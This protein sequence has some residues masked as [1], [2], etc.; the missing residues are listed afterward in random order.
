MCVTKI[1]ARFPCFIAFIESTQVSTIVIIFRCV[2][3]SFG[4][5]ETGMFTLG[6]YTTFN[7]LEVSIRDFTSF[8]KGEGCLE[9]FS[10]LQ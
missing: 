3:L 8:N 10:P 7:R 4:K 1:C 6:L 9:S 2:G 5:R